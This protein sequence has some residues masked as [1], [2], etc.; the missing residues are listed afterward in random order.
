[1][2]SIYAVPFG[3]MRYWLQWTAACHVVSGLSHS[4]IQ[5]TTSFACVRS[6]FVRARASRTRFILFFL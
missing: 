5:I 3:P 1:M 6:A 4:P 2:T